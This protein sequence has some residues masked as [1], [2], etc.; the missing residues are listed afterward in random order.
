VAGY[1]VQIVWSTLPALAVTLVVGIACFAALG[2][3]VVALVGS[4][5]AVQAITTG[6]LIP[7]AFVSDIFTFSGE[8]PSWLARLGWVFPLKHFANAVADDL[9]P[10]LTGSGFYADHLA[11]MGL[12]GLGALLVAVR[13]FR[14]DRRPDRR[15]GHVSPVAAAVGTTRSVTVGHPP[16]TPIE[17]A[18]RPSALSLVAGQVRYANRGTWRD[19]SA[20]FFSVV[21]PVLLL[22]FFRVAY[23]GAS[24]EG[25]PL[26]Q[27]ATPAFAVYGVAVAAYVNL[28]ESVSEAR[29]RGVL[30]R[31][32]GTPLSPW[33]YHAGRIGSAFAVAAL[34]VG[35]TFAVG[36]GFLDVRVRLSA[37]PGLTLTYLL[38]TACFTAL[39]MA[40]VALTDSTRTATALTLGT[41]L[42]LSFFSGIFL[43]GDLPAVMSAIGWS[44]P[45]RHFVVA[46]FQVT[47]PNGTAWA[48]WWG[49]LAVLVVWGVLA[50]V[51]ASRFFRWESRRGTRRAAD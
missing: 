15:R 44:F 27:Y 6:T 40:V 20:V 13:F 19:P 25:V 4:P 45:L 48:Q 9:N 21:F 30:E 16:G 23:K 39:G 33:A 28:P 3:A 2:L 24:V 46:A 31:L 47:D 38:G 50:T 10:Y 5:S 18:G 26:A 41:L 37:L 1:G 32:R 8:L 49:H 42:P 22:V 11:V 7:L 34:I 17:H 14:W 43:I 12:W 29:E 35:L 36:T 51:V